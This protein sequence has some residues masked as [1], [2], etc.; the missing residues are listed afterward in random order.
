[1]AKAAPMSAP[2]SVNSGVSAQ[3]MLKIVGRSWCVGFSISV[4]PA[5]LCLGNTFLLCSKPVSLNFGGAQGLLWESNVN[6]IAPSTFAPL[7]VL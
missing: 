2:L 5:A 7:H 1:M 4:C 3:L 6:I